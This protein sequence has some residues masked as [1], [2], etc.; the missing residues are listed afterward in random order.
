[1]TLTNDERNAMRAF[2]QRCEVRLSTLHRIGLG[3][4]SGAG[5][6]LLFPVFLKDAFDGTAA[7]FLNEA[8][9]H[10][11]TMGNNGLALT[12]VLYVLLAY[13]LIMALAVPLYGVYLLIKD[14]VHFYFTIYMPGMLGDLQTPS[15]GLTGLTFWA[16]ET[17]PEI[18]R[19]VMAYQYTHG[20]MDYMLPFSDQKR[21]E[22]L[23]LLYE[24]TNQQ[25]VPPTRTPEAL[26]ELD[27]IPPE[28]TEADVLRFGTAFGMTYSLDRTLVQDVAMTEMAL[29]RHIL[30]L[31]RL[32]MRYIKTLLVF[33]WTTII[34]FVALP[35]L[36][37]P[38]LP[39]LVIL[40]FV[41]LVWGVM[42]LP[43][44]QWPLLWIYRHRRGDIHPEHIDTQLNLF[45][46]AVRGWCITAIVSSVG[47]L[48]L[49]LISLLMGG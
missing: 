22:Y 4:I 21:H 33:L 30:Y 49:A 1:M 47:A 18:K 17:N 7:I 46:R 19:Q 37:D 12:V 35:F 9:N 32:M 28:T 10:F 43:I 42:V 27:V 36:R 24:R 29:S 39:S 8:R 13:P 15:F 2:L 3:F 26:R 44:L 14:V 40:A 38:R 23:D 31:R 41:Y 11:P 48:T 5:L 34:L 45:N 16:D 25:I 6:L 20:H